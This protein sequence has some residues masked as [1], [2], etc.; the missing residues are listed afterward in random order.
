MKNFKETILGFIDG[1]YVIETTR[2]ELEEM[3]KMPVWNKSAK[4]EG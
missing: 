2:K 4:K 1:T 3:K